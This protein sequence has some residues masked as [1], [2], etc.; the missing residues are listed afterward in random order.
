MQLCNVLFKLKKK[1]FANSRQR[2]EVLDGGTTSNY[3]NG[4]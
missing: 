1:D 4:E 3:Q 2:Q